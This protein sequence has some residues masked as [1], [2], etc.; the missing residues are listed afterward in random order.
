MR[1]EVRIVQVGIEGRH[2]PRRQ[3]TLVDDD[4]RRQGA[5]VEGLTLHQFFIPAQLVGAVFAY[6]IQL[7]LEL[8]AAHA[9]RGD[10]KLFHSGHGGSSGVADTRAVGMYW[11]HAPTQQAL[12]GVGNFAFDQAL[13]LCAFVGVGR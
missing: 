7:A 2:L 1:G 3:H 6:Q 13:A 11:Y 9:L 8:V 5:D 4:L 12:T 10:E